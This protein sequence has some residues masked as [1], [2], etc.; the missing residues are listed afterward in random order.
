MYRAYDAFSSRI[1]DADR[2]KLT[3]YIWRMKLCM[4]LAVGNGMATR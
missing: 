4:R 2:A 1:I 3:Y